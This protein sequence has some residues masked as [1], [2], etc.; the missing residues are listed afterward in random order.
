VYIRLYNTIFKKY[1][2]IIYISS[3]IYIYIYIYCPST[4]NSTH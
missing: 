3:D 1:T 4:Q 2:S